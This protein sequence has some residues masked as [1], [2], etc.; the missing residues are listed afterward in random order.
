MSK[1]T[2]LFDF[3]GTIADTLSISIEIVNKN[4]EK[5]GIRKIDPNEIERLKDFTPWQLLKEF[6]VPLYKLPFFVT[7]FQS[8]MYMAIDRVKPFKELPEILQKLHQ[9][10]FTL[11]IVTSNSERNVNNFLKNNSLKMFDF[12]HNERNVF[13]KHH[14][15]NKVLKEKHLVKEEVFYVGDE[16]RDIEACAKSGIRMIAVTWG[17]NS[18]RILEKYAPSFLI[19]S[20]KELLDIVRE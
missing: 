6:R 20:P 9:K 2:L 3:D 5:Y 1:K 19:H 12:V 7:K 15:I 8:E 16:V 10:G 17:Y 18:R 13:G 11:G 14:T 4:A